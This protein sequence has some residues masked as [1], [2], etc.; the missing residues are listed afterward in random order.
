[1][2]VRC[3]EDHGTARCDKPKEAPPK[4]ANCAE[5]HPANYRGCQIAKIAQK[6]REELQRLIRRIFTSNMVKESVA[7]AR[8]AQ[9]NNTTAEKRVLSLPETSRTPFSL[10]SEVKEIK[11]MLQAFIVSQNQNNQQFNERLNIIEARQTGAIPKR[12]SLQIQRP[13][14]CLMECQWHLK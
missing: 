4:C 6:R 8:A 10:E 11:D 7:Y 1:M 9:N 2:C 14:N 3:A 5:S 12:K 13:Q